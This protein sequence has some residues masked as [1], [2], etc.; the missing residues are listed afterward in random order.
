M[1]RMISAILLLLLIVASTACENNTSSPQTNSTTKS[2]KDPAPELITGTLYAV[3][4]EDEI[5]EFDFEYEYGTCTPEMIAEALSKWTG[6]DFNITAA[7]NMQSNTVT[8]DWSADST[9]AIGQP[10]ESQKK[11]FHFYDEEQLR[12]FMLN[13]LCHTIRENMGQLDVFYS[14]EGDGDNMNDL[15]LDLD[16]NPA[17]AYNKLEDSRVL[18]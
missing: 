17:I 2:T 9:L 8:I 10:P 14:L 5:R 6:L 12:F 4:S 16:F 1:K 7:L 13:S 15:G 18:K 3:F 11:E